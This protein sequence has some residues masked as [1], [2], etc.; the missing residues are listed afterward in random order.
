[1]L[2]FVDESGDCGMSGKKGSSRFF[3]VTTVLFEDNDS[4]SECDECISNLRSKLR[5]H[6]NYEFHFNKCH[7]R[8]KERFLKGVLNQDFLYLSVVLNKSK[9]WGEGFQDKESFYKYTA[10]LVF[11]NAK[12]QL[13]NAT[14]VIDKCGEREFRQ[15]LSKYLKRRINQGGREII[16]KVR[17][18]PSHS[19][20]LLQLTDM[21]TGA[22]SRSFRLDKADRW[23]FRR[24]VRPRELRVQVWPK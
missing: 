18:E 3:V 21:I 4:A 11:Q 14:I 6:R 22:V 7:N 10:N 13:S 2:A 8:V 16:K 15:S 9:L 23:A 20:N 5:L 12:P 1:M 19:N 24:I 17:M